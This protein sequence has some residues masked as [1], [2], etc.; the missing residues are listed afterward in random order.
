[1]QVQA[2][3]VLV[4]YGLAFASWLLLVS[5]PDANRAFF[6]LTLLGVAAYSVHYAR[7]VTRDSGI[8]SGAR[9][10]ETCLTR[11]YAGVMRAAHARLAEAR[12]NPP[13]AAAIAVVERLR[14]R[15]EGA[16]N[17]ATLLAEHFATVYRKILM[18]PLPTVSEDAEELQQLVDIMGDVRMELVNTIE[19]LRLKVTAQQ[20]ALVQ[21]A[22]QLALGAT[23]RCMKVVRNRLRSFDGLGGRRRPL[24]AGTGGPKPHDPSAS[25]SFDLYI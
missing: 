9:A 5:Y 14:D 11:A 21:R 13:L 15:D 19:S 17:T 6:V 20:E 22:V 23:Y 3:V 12:A 2:G 7:R 25:T 24:L 8:E 4:A 10:A 16:A 18:A 1:M